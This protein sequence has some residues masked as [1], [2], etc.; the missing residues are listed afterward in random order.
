MNLKIMT[1]SVLITGVTGNLGSVCSKYFNQDWNVT[2]VSRSKFL[3]TIPTINGPMAIEGRDGGIDL[4]SASSV[5]EFLDLTINDTY[6]LVV[7][8]H[9]VVDNSRIEHISQADWNRVIDSNL[10][11]C[12]VLTSELIATNKLNP[13]AL[14][15]YCSSIQADLPREGRYLYGLSKLGLEL[16]AKSVHVENAPRIRAVALRLGQM[17]RLMAGRQFTDEE[18]KAIENYTP[19]PWVNCLDVAKLVECLY[20]Q[21]S[22]SGTTINVDSGHNLSVWPK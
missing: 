20:D 10:K 11:S 22:L 4:C 18:R 1:K 3:K 15:I 12:V 13:N 2:G 7:M 6:D 17:E 16:L 5:A 8:A 21:K 9:G 14:I 19:L